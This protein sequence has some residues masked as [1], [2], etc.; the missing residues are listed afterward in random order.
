LIEEIDRLFDEMVRSRWRRVPSAPRATRAEGSSFEVE[1]PLSDGEHGDVFV[2]VEGRRLTVGW[3]ARGARSG[4]ARDS[5]ASG[6]VQ[7]QQ[8]QRTFALPEGVDVGAVEA[9]FEGTVLRVRVALR[10]A[11]D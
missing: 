6:T 9:R 5:A 11:R 7:T 3:R 4:A 2:G 1:I 10:P 8:Q